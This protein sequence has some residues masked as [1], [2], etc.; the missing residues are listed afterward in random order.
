MAFSDTSRAT[1]QSTRPEPSNTVPLASGPSLRSVRF[2]PPSWERNGSETNHGNKKLETFTYVSSAFIESK[3][4]EGSEIDMSRHTQDP[5]DSGNRRVQFETAR[6][7]SH[8]H[9]SSHA[10][11]TAYQAEA[12]GNRGGWGLGWLA[13]TSSLIIL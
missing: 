2:L 1:W 7:A 8:T 11:G 12:K 5:F 13:R 4:E 9:P 10:I 6:D 3:Q